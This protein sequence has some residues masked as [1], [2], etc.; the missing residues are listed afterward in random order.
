MA[1]NEVKTDVRKNIIEASLLLDSGLFDDEPED[2]VETP[3]LV[4]QESARVEEVTEGSSDDAMDSGFSVTVDNERVLSDT[5]KAQLEVIRYFLKPE[6]V[7]KNVEARTQEKL[8]MP[9]K[10]KVKATRPPDFMQQRPV[11]K[12][13]KPQVRSHER[14]KM[15]LECNEDFTRTQVKDQEGKMAIREIKSRPKRKEKA[16]KHDTTENK[17]PLPEYAKRG[18]AVKA[19]VKR[20]KLMSMTMGD[21]RPG[22]DMKLKMDMEMNVEQEG[23]KEYF[24]R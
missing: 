21:M 17:G 4:E 18:I 12:A 22:M 19:K 3:T 2:A 23:I 24:R 10:P 16:Q 13:D 9:E 14:S 6:T 15:P 7:P 1:D 8:K 11:A 5:R 20:D